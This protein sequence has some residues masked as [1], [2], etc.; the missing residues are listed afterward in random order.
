MTKKEAEEA[1]KYIKGVEHE[2]RAWD[3]VNKKM[4]SE[5]SMNFSKENVRKVSFLLTD[6]HYCLSNDV[7]NLPQCE[8]LILMRCSGMKDKNGK[9]MFVGDIYKKYAGREN[10]IMQIVLPNEDHGGYSWAY[11]IIEYGAKPSKDYEV[12][13]N[14]F[15][16]PEL[17]KYIKW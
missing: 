15:E 7:S 12:I 13:G 17:Y 11:S 1:I 4:V 6:I 3:T 14:I 8:D 10:P 2:Y 5:F 9:K 16:N